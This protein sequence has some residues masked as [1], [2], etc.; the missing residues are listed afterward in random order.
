M[1]DDAETSEQTTGSGGLVLFFFFSGTCS[2]VCLQ[3]S[4]AAADET[5][6]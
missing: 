5:A 4:E 2:G 3:I 6:G 1:P